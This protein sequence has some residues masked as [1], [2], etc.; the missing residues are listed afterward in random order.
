MAEQMADALFYEHEVKEEVAITSLTA[1]LNDDPVLVKQ[2]RARPC[3]KQDDRLIDGCVACLVLGCL[4]PARY[5]AAHTRGHATGHEE[6][7]PRP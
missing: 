1:Q 3:I 7:L 2:V 5:S 4:R 6:Y